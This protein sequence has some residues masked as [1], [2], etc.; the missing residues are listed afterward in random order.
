MFSSAGRT[1]YRIMVALK[2]GKRPVESQA[3]HAYFLTVGFP[4]GHLFCYAGWFNAIG[5]AM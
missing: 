4:G 2:S 5:L 1:V 3:D